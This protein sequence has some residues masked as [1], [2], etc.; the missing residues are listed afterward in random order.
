M[1][2]RKKWVGEF[3]G[4]RRLSGQRKWN[5]TEKPEWRLGLGRQEEWDWNEG[6]TL[7]WETGGF[8]TKMIN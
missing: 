4:G 8:R 1:E 6:T 3:R 2:V 7:R 5:W